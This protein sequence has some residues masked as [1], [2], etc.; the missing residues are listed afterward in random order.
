ML[1]MTSALHKA[2]NRFDDAFFCVVGT[3]EPAA[4]SARLTK[5]SAIIVFIPWIQASV[6]AARKSYF[7]G[8]RQFAENKND[9]YTLCMF[10]FRSRIQALSVNNAIF[11]PAR[12]K[13]R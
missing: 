11:L 10:C 8:T 12:Q 6:V 7:D 3:M 2:A 4:H 13:N 5:L 9:L 1:A